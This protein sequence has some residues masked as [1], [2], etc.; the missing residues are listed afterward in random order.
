MGLFTEGLISG[1]HTGDVC[2]R[3][4]PIRSGRGEG[5]G[6]LGRGPA[7]EIREREGGPEGAVEVTRIDVENRAP[8][9]GSC[10]GEDALGEAGIEQD[11]VEGGRLDQIRHRHSSTDSSASSSSSSSSSLGSVDP[12]LCFGSEP[13]LRSRAFRCLPR[14][15]AFHLLASDS[16]LAFYMSF[17]AHFS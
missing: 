4:S 16:N 13:L 12:S 7:D 10:G 2:L 17:F 5:K 14:I 9:G 15:L 1:E 11:E 8:G 6:S 3:G